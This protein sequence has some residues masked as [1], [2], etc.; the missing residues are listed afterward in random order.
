MEETTSKFE[1]AIGDSAMWVSP[2][3]EFAIGGRV[4]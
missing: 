3:D 4:K 2:T 1:V